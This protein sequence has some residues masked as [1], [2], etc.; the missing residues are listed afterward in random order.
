[1]QVSLL[2][3]GLNEILRQKYGVSGI[4]GSV[5]D[6][7]NVGDLEV[8]KKMMAQKLKYLLAT[9]GKDKKAKK[10]KDKSG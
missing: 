5:G 7:K 2:M 6:D 8:E 10:K 4:S 9:R 1:M 3:E